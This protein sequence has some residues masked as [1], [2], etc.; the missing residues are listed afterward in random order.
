MDRNNENFRD[1]VII[2]TN[3]KSRPIMPPIIFF[4]F[5]RPVFHAPNHPIL[6]PF[7]KHF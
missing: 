5:I 7:R 3:E 1:D 6:G 2:K 4:T